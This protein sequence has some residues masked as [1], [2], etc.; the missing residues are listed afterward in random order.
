M[1]MLRGYAFPSMYHQ[2]NL[3]IYSSGRSLVIDLMNATISGFES[4]INL[5]ITSQSESAIG[6]LLQARMAYNASGVVAYWTPGS[7]SGAPG[8]I[9]AKPTGA[10]RLFISI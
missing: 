4:L 9:T 2:S 8:S 6:K 7:T 1:N 3:H 10:R 5:P